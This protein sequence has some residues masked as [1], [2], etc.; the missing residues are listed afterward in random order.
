M[1]PSSDKRH[2]ITCEEARYTVDHQVKKIENTHKKALGL[3]R[4]NILIAGLLLT[5]LSLS[6]ESSNVDVMKFR[7]ISSLFGIFLLASSSTFAATTYTSSAVDVGIKTDFESE[8]DGTDIQTVLKGNYL[9][10][11]NHNEDVIKF[12]SYVFTLAIITLIGSIV[13]L[14]AGIYT[15]I[16]SSNGVSEEYWWFFVGG[17]A[18]AI[19]SGIVWGAEWVSTKIMRL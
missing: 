18:W 13:F 15:G 10:W 12:N 9:G 3:F 19:M 17:A 8:H 2:S 7:N 4:V 1:A 14:G 5:I 11:M 16:L 6:I